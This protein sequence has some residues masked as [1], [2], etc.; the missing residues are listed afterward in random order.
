[1]HSAKTWVVL[2][3]SLTFVA[4]RELGKGIRA[5]CQSC[6]LQLYF[7]PRQPFMY[8]A[9]NSFQEHSHSIGELVVLM[10][11]WTKSFPFVLTS[12]ESDC[13]CASQEHGQTH[14]EDRPQP[15]SLLGAKPRCPRCHWGSTLEP[16]C[17]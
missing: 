10:G 8:P 12:D 3:S 1:M 9:K 11:A 13:N 15:G 6:F 4:Y 17:L 5:L 14:V 16:A 7:L 2:W